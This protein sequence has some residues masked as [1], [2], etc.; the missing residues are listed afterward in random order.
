MNKDQVI[1]KDNEVLLNFI[2]GAHGIISNID[3]EK[4]DPEDVENFMIGLTCISNL[5]IDQV[6]EEYN[7]GADVSAVDQTHKIVH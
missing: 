4:Q 7:S 2:S 1:V 5:I 6:H 3:L